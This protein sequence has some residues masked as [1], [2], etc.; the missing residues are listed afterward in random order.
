MLLTEHSIM[1]PIVLSA[2]CLPSIS[3]CCMRFSLQPV[4]IQQEVKNDQM[5]HLDVDNRQFYLFEAIQDQV[6]P[7]HQE[8][9]LI[10]LNKIH[11][12]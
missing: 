3:T 8:H 9:A 12:Q 2:I 7:I 10:A 4:V 5:V 11:N 6:D 1:C